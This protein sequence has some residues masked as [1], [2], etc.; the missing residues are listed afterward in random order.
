M[1]V[2]LR[3]RGKARNARNIALLGTGRRR[4]GV[5]S[6]PPKRILAYLRTS[7]GTRIPRFLP[8]LFLTATLAVAPPLFAGEPTAADKET[9]RTLVT[10]GQS[11][12]DAKDFAGALKSFRA[13]HAIMNLPT[14][15]LPLGKAQIELGLLVEARDTLLE[16]ARYPKKA[17]EP[18]AFGRARTE[19]SQ[20]SDSLASRIATLELSFPSSRPGAAAAVNID[21]VE[22]PS[23]AVTVP[24]RVNPGKHLIVVRVD[25]YE[26][27]TIETTLGDGE[28]KLVPVPLKETGQT[29]IASPGPAPATPP[30]GT[31][32]PADEGPTTTKTS[33]LVYIGFGVGGA[34]IVV[35]TVTGLM[36]VS[37]ASSAK[38]QCID[39][40]CPPAA[41]SDIDSAKTTGTISTIGFAVGVVGVAVGVYGLLSPSK[42]EGKVSADARRSFSVTPVVGP[43]SFSLHGRF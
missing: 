35:G 28:A 33:P 16:V 21:G 30:P 14:T 42:V 39:T 1:A 20:L 22:I 10:K 25:G 26:P 19:A 2:S 13:A 43:G 23:E 11:L 40:R 15:G 29:K 12:Y 6:L 27:T 9:A 4:L 31:P 34:G 38:D 41:Q 5:V 18:E 7:M 37:S 17:S 24:R 32:P 8:L 36:A 3:H